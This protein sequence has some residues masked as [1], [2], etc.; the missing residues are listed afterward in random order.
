MNVYLINIVCLSV[1]SANAHRSLV[2]LARRN[3]QTRFP[4]VVML[5]RPADSRLLSNL[6]Q[7]DKEYSNN[8]PAPP[9]MPPWPLCSLCL[10]L[11]SRLQAHWRGSMMLSNDMRGVWTSEG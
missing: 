7:Q 10:M 5:H 8:L 4:E 9:R 3:L 1:S 6:L 11:S 2:A